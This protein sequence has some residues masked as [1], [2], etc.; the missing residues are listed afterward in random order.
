[1]TD[2]TLTDNGVSFTASTMRAA[3]KGLR[4]ALEAARAKE[5]AETAAKRQATLLA[6]S[7]AYSMINQKALYNELPRR[8][9]FLTLEQAIER[10]DV[11]ELA[12]DCGT[13]KLRITTWQE[14]EP[15]SAT[16][17]FSRFDNLAGFITNSLGVIGFAAAFSMESN[18]A[19]HV[20]GL[21][22]QSGKLNYTQAHG[23]MV[24]DFAREESPAAVADPVEA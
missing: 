11:K 17:E 12:E 18:A 13:K 3:R 23:I 2:I 14:S 19:P 1:M 16:I 6:N 8:W 20:Y 10:R 7:N 9:K 15:Q 5:Q 24:E 21:G 4:E 22:I